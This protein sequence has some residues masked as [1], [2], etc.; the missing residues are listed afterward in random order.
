MAYKNKLNNI[1]SQLN[2]LISSKNNRKNYY[3]N[4]GSSSIFVIIGIILLLVVIC[5]L[6]YFL[7]KHFSKVRKQMSTSKLLVPYI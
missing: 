1:N 2:K 3:Y 4:K 5:V 7:Y 6:G